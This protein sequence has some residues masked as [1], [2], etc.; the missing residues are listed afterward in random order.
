MKF[1]TKLFYLKSNEKHKKKIHQPLQIHIIRADHLKKTKQKKTSVYHYNYIWLKYF[2][3]FQ[4]ACVFYVFYASIRIGG[5]QNFCLTFEL[6]E[7]MENKIQY[8]GLVESMTKFVYAYT[9]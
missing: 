6:I 8:Y 2:V 1:V 3:S 5:F 4:Y 9:P 7:R